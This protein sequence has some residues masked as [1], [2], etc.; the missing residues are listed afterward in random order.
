VYLRQPELPILVTEVE[1]D[2]LKIRWEV[3]DDLAFPMP[4]DIQFGDEIRRV[5]VPAE[6]IVIKLE[7]DTEP[8]LDPENWILYQDPYPEEISLSVKDLEGFVGTYETEF[9]NRI[10]KVE[11]MKEGQSIY[12]KSAR[13]PK[14]QLF[15]SS[16]SEFFTKVSD[17]IQLKFNLG[18]SGQIKSVT[19]SIFPRELTY[20]KIN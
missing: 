4:I 1:N 8:I 14:I 11:I 16:E 6:G 19:Y 9:R 17:K 5:E 7:E 2:Q 13:F 12:V 20:Q 10:R 18:E 3:P 15:P